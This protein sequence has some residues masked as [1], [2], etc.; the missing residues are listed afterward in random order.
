MRLTEYR[1][2]YDVRVRQPHFDRV[3]FV[4]YQT[5]HQRD[6]FVGEDNVATAVKGHLKYK[7]QY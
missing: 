5:D 6:R 1:P 4:L 2:V 7:R 3:V